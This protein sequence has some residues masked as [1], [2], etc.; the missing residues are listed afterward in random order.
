MRVFRARVLLSLGGCS[1]GGFP[2]VRCAALLFGRCRLGSVVLPGNGFP[3]E[4]IF[5]SEN[6]SLVEV[7]VRLLRFGGSGIKFRCGSAQNRYRAKLI[8]AITVTVASHQAK[9]KA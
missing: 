6:H 1:V 9:L 3:S 5:V 8:A 2:A 7:C 4:P